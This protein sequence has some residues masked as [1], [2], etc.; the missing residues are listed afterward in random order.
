M[1]PAFFVCFRNVLRVLAGQWPQE[2]PT[3]APETPH[4]GPGNVY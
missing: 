3:N 2:G 1:K 4:Q